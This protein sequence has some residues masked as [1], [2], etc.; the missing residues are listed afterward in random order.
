MVVI[1][2][3]VKLEV[4]KPNYIQ[5]IIAKQ[6]DC[7]SR[8]LKVTLADQGVL[9]PI[10]STSTVLINAERKD[11]ESKSFY[12]EVNDDNTAT[13]PLTSWILELDGEVKCDVSVINVEGRKLTST[14]FVVLVEKTCNCS[15]DIVTD[16]AY[17]VLINLINE[18]NE[19][20]ENLAT[21]DQNYNPESENPQSG[22]AVAEAIAEIG[23]GGGSTQVDSMLS[24]ESENPVQNKVITKTLQYTSQGFSADLEI[25]SPGWKRILNLIRAS[26]GELH[27]GLAK[28]RAASGYACQSLGI[29]VT[30]NVNFYRVADDTTP[31]I[32]QLYNHEM[33]ENNSSDATRRARITKVRLGYPEEGTDFP[34]NT[35]SI[36]YTTNPVNCYLDIYV[37][38]EPQL[39]DEKL[40]LHMHYSGYAAANNCEPITEETEATDIGMYGE[41][42]RFHEFE[43]KKNADLYIP[44]GSL[45]VGELKAASADIAGYVKNTDRIAPDKFGLVRVPKLDTGEYGLRLNTDGS[46]LLIA[47]ATKTDIDER[48][49]SYKPI[50][51]ARLEYAVTSVGDT[52]YALKGESGGGSNPIEVAKD[53]Y[54]AKHSYAGF[55]LFVDEEGGLQTDMN[56]NGFHHRFSN[57]LGFGLDGALIG[58]DLSYDELKLY[59]RVET[60]NYDDDGMP[61]YTEEDDFRLNRTSVKGNSA[62]KKSFQNWLGVP[63]DALKYSYQY[64]TADQKKQAKQNLGI[65]E[66]A[67][68]IV[69]QAD[70]SQM[71]E[72]AGTDFW[73]SCAGFYRVW[74]TGR[75]EI[76][77]H[78]AGA[79][80]ADNGCWIYLP[81]FN[82]KNISD[83][84]IVGM[85]PY[86]SEVE[87]IVYDSNETFYLMF[88]TANST[89][90]KTSLHIV[91][92]IN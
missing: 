62:L 3:D 78:L 76:I 13:V 56:V 71:E 86:R 49:N 57:D 31:R 47:Q 37:D 88:T 89:I 16:P 40:S 41:T 60:G 58:V 27:L 4:S 61:I 24:L 12:G 53:E 91:G 42:L 25:R 73:P 90:G 32:Y 72:D 81:Y 52:R 50:T 85:F 35:E 66:S 82:N 79:R 23:T 19:A 18:V 55:S 67:E 33:G 75:F 63:T 30:G 43:V 65:I 20:K 70:I 15:D 28:A 26:G 10:Q 14:S 54:S 69:E 2:T 84:E 46:G 9:I 38:F 51:P 45:E 17:D 77:L 83:L 6:N 29:N 36:N 92:K 74:N 48:K 34:Q 68:Y 1:V 5:A 8:F 59:R 21:I 11:G 39:E 7:N 64:L 22:K 80:S 44:N 87:N